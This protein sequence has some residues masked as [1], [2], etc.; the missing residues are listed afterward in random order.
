L[1]GTC[2]LSVGFSTE[3]SNATAPSA[4]IV[5]RA[6]PPTGLP[7]AGADPQSTTAV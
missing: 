4:K 3:A 5:K 7:S 2:S 1:V 6:F